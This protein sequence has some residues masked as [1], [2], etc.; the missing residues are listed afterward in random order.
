M[1]QLLQCYISY[2][3][4]SYSATTSILNYLQSMVHVKQSYKETC[5]LVAND[6][7]TERQRN[8]YQK[9][10]L[11]RK[12]AYDQRSTNPQA[13]NEFNQQ[14][15]KKIN[16]R[17]NTEPAPK[18]A[19][20]SSLFNTPQR[21]TVSPGFQVEEIECQPDLQY[22]PAQ[23]EPSVVEPE[24]EL[25]STPHIPPPVLTLDDGE[26]AF[27]GSP[28]TPMRS[29]QE[30]EDVLAGVTKQIEEDQP[31]SSPVK[32]RRLETP[33]PSSPPRKRRSESPDRAS[34]SSRS[35]SP[36]PVAAAPPKRPRRNTLK[37][38]SKGIAFVIKD[39]GVYSCITG[40]STY[41]KGKLKRFSANEIFMQ[42]MFIAD[43]E[44]DL[45]DVWTKL[46]G[47]IL[48]KFNCR[49]NNK[50]ISTKKD[51]DAYRQEL[52]DYIKYQLTKMD[53]V[54]GNSK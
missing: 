12:A 4:K 46:A 18:R 8:A 28:L 22:E 5:N 15:A 49:K 14:R 27:A 50:T 11:K 48:A 26:Y 29:T 3:Q 35:R 33:P 21:S 31:P 54:S 17:R 13:F 23:Y 10:T 45:A 1:Y 32:R 41:L 44:V 2:H 39:K 40:Y 25:A 6:E 47:K 42:P 52:H 43:D 51:S 9:E 34:S 37:N 30:L 19:R 36:S 16:N 24:I 7:D 20:S 53:F 38:R